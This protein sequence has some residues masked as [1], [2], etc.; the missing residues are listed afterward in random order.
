ME[1]GARA[2][3]GGISGAGLVWRRVLAGGGGGGGR[4]SVLFQC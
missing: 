3:V 2:A 4:D 1:E